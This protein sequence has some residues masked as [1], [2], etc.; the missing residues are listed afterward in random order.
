MGAAI[1]PLDA[2][3]RCLD[4]QATWHTLMSARGTAGRATVGK[5]GDARPTMRARAAWMYAS[6]TRHVH[7][8]LRGRD[9]A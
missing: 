6:P 7:L 9:G 2:A 4:E 3:A 8:R 1:L 5:R